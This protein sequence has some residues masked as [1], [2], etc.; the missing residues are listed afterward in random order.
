MLMARNAPPL[1]MGLG[2]RTGDILLKT[3]TANKRS[4]LGDPLPPVTARLLGR[5]LGFGEGG[6]DRYLD[7]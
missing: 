1:P 4:Y 6:M 2:A 5:G 7:R 3:E